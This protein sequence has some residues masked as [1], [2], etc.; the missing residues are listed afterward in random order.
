MFKVIAN[1][2]EELFQSEAE[3][4]AL[5]MAEMFASL[6]ARAGHLIE[7]WEVEKEMQPVSK[8]IPAHAENANVLPAMQGESLDWNQEGG[9]YQPAEGKARGEIPG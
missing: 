4:V 3:S 8:A 7:V 5:E 9:S 2:E 6:P 1:G